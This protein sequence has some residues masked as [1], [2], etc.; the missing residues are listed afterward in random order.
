[1]RRP[2]FWEFLAE[3]LF[4]PLTFAWFLLLGRAT[5]H[6]TV[7]LVGGGLIGVATACLAGYALCWIGNRFIGWLDK[8]IGDRSYRE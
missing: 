8:R 5:G 2:A 6:F 3:L 7:A 4:V 1:M